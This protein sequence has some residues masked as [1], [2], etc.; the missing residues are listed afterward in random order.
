[1][2]ERQ[3]TFYLRNSGSYSN[4]VICEAESLSVRTGATVTSG[5]QFTGHVEPQSDF[6]FPHHSDLLFAMFPAECIHKTFQDFSVPVP[7]Y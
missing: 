1:L 5:F 7:Q 6:F 2:I 3:F 4:P